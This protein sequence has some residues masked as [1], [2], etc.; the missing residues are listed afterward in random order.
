MRGGMRIF[1]ADDTKKTEVVLENRRQ[2]PV[3]RNFADAIVWIPRSEQVV[4][5]KDVGWGE[6]GSSALTYA[7]AEGFRHYG[8]GTPPPPLFLYSP[9][10]HQSPW[11]PIYHGGFTGCSLPGR[12]GSLSLICP[13]I[14][15]SGTFAFDRVDCQVL[16]VI[17]RSQTQSESPS[18]SEMPW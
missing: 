6:G 5:S 18:P 7:T 16:S 15:S 14:V 3:V 12:G 8:P 9:P 1:S 10:R 13:D 11:K 17:L 2:C 4:R